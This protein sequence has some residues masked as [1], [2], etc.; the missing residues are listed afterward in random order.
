MIESNGGMLT[1]FEP[2]KSGNPNGRPKGSKNR[3]T[4]AK[5]WLETREEVVNPMTNEPEW[6]TQEDIM[7][8]AL[9]RKARRG[10]V[11]AYNALMVSGYG[12][13]KPEGNNDTNEGVIIRIT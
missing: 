12:I 10:D 2:G 7:T 9:I 8:M 13:P 5:K 4:I 1:P 3:S 11:N 6:L